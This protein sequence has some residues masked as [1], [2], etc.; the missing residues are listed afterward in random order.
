MQDVNGNYSDPVTIHITVFESFNR[1]PVGITDEYGTPAETPLV[2]AAPGLAANDFDP[3]G[4][5]FLVSNFTQTTNGTI[6]S[7]LTNGSFTYVPDAGFTGTD[8][9]S[10]TLLD[11]NG[12]YSDP[13]TVTITVIEINEPPVASATNPTVECSSPTGTMVTLDGSGSTDPERGTLTYTWYVNNNII[14]GPSSSSTANVNFTSGTHQVTLKV[15]DECGASSETNI[16]VTVQDTEPPV[17]EAKFLPT[18]KKHEYSISCSTSDVCSPIVSTRSLILIPNLINPAISL[19]NKDGYSLEIDESK[20]TVS[21]EAPDAATFWAMVISNGGILVNGGQLIGAKY[22]KKKYKY[23]FDN[24]GNLL[25]VSGDVLSLRCSATDG[26][27]NTGVGETSLPMNEEMIVSRAAPTQTSEHSSFE[28]RNYP[29]PFTEKTN[30]QFHLSEKAFVQ[31]NILDVSGRVV[32][33]ISSKQMEAGEHLFIW[34]AK[35]RAGGVYF[36]QI[37]YN[38]KQVIK[39]M[40]LV[41]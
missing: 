36:Y 35:G 19:K 7:I 14:V 39:K 3:D 9:F 37:R 12:N 2:I 30:I 18:A 11:A 33:K 41:R 26:N 17:V 8:Q 23:S 15:E 31:I 24:N 28:S 40:I 21:V 20:N 29:N 13:V 1:K 5:D 6:T 10:Y 38:D 16:T 32:D 22:D 34:D 4:D 27:G 25:S